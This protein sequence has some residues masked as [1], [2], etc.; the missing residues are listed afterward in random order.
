MALSLEM[1]GRW[2][3]VVIAIMVAVGLIIGFRGEILN[4]IGG[5]SPDGD[6]ESDVDIVDVDGGRDKHAAQLAD[7]V[8]LC[9]DRS[10]E[11]GYK[12]FTCFLA[13]SNQGSF[14]GVTAREVEEFLEGDVA[15]KTVFKNAPYRRES[16]IV[17]YRLEDDKI[18]VEE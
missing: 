18:V 2:V 7:L 16:V 13:R 11:T 12:G 10:L 14:Q 17:K 1:V 4:S 6:E 9:H 3:L 5:I 8:S 15:E